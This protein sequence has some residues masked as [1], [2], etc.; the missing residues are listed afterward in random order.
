ME[1]KMTIMA[2]VAA[3]LIIA[4][5]YS[6][7]SDSDLSQP[8]GVQGLWSP[9]QQECKVESQ[10]TPSGGGGDW[11]DYSSQPSGVQGLD[12]QECRCGADL[13]APQAGV[14]YLNSPT[15]P[16]GVQGLWPSDPQRKC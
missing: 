12:K 2:I 13:T 7:A 1:K 8:A 11:M 6:F 4:S 5:G 9:G 14:D 15:Q 16:A 10:M 3:M